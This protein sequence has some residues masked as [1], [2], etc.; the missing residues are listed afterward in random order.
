MAQSPAELLRQ[1]ITSEL[2][3]L[4]ALPAETASLK[5]ADPTRWSPKQE[6][7]HLVDSAVNNHQRFVRAALHG[8]YTGPGY[9]QNGWVE[10]H[11]YQNM[12]WE[13]IVDLW[14]RFNAFLARVVDRIPESSLETPCKVGPYPVETLGFVIQ[15]YVVHMQHHLDHLLGRAEITQYPQTR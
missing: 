12:S 5:P 6:L 2:P 8:D 11:D 9:D 1:T 4:E 15:D 10:L 7:G 14:F 13:N 3:L